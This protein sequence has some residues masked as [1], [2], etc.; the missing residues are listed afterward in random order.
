MTEDQKAA[1]LAALHCARIVIGG[2]AD[3]LPRAEIVRR[4][5]D[6][7]NTLPLEVRTLTEET[8]A[9]VMGEPFRQAA[10]RLMTP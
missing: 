5:A 8:L 6:Y 9:E 4:C 3:A 2:Q 1:N 10:G 7:V